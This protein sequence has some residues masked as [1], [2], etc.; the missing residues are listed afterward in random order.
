MDMG[1]HWRDIDWPSFYNTCK[2]NHFVAMIHSFQ[3]YDIKFF[4]N[5]FD[6]YLLGTRNTI[7]NFIFQYLKI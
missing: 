6:M 7:T 1:Y 4:I 2:I 3:N 5:L